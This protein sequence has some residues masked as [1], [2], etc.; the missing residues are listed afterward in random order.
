MNRKEELKA[1]I[2]VAGQKLYRDAWDI[3]ENCKLANHLT[4]NMTQKDLDQIN[5]FILQ[6]EQLKEYIEDLLNS[7]L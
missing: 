1:I 2:P 4:Q 7:K 5:H 6:A 3:A